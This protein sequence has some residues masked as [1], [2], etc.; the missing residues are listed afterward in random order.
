MGFEEEDH[1]SSWPFSSH[2][3]KGNGIDVTSLPKLTCHQADVVAVRFLHGETSPSHPTQ[4]SLEGSHFAY[5]PYFRAGLRLQ[6]LLRKLSLV[7]LQENCACSPSFTYLFNVL[8][9]SVWTHRYFFHTLGD[10]PILCYF[11]LFL[12]LFQLQTFGALSIGSY[13]PLT[14]PHQC[15]F[16]CWFL[17]GAL[18]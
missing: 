17:L 15:G 1:R 4:S 2:L 6:L 12:Q 9:I 16:F 18:S 3:I 14:F 8:F 11:I 5:S 13:V 10:N 7:L